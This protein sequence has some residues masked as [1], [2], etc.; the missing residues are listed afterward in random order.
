MKMPIQKILLAYIPVFHRGY[1]FLFQWHRDK[2][3]SLVILGDSLIDEFPT[4]A[5]EIRA[6]APHRAKLVVESL[7]LFK[8][9]FVLERK[10]V[11]KIS[12]QS[13]VVVRD[14]LTEKVVEKY[15]PE[16]F[17]QW[18]TSFLRWDEKNVLSLRN[19]QFDRTASSEFDQKMMLEA[20][21][22]AEPSSSWWRRV[23][24]IVVKDGEILLRAHN[25]HT[26]SEYTNFMEGDPRDFIK[27]GEKSE[28][29]TAL[30][31]EQLVVA[32]AAEKGL[33]LDGTSLYVTV[34]PCPSCA[35]LVAYSGIKKIFFKEGHASLD[36]ER[37]LRFRGVEIIK[38]K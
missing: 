20:I 37:I 27:A 36:G 33:K 12:G 10:D 17:V 16:N 26:P 15:F 19:V 14:A 3:E 24:A 34:F 35:K 25:F 8:R 11:S 5:K 7:N 6:L 28:L 13:L 23:G 21:K 22:E 1:D 30:H 18:D 32:S 29:G 31:A 38:V 2:V 4:V 9:V